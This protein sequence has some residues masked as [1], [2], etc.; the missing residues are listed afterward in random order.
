M[1]FKQYIK[2]LIRFIINGIPDVNLTTTITTLSKN[3]LLKGRTALITGGTSGIGKSIARSFLNAGATVI[4]TGRSKNKIDITIEDIKQSTGL[5]SVYGL[6]L[7]LANIKDMEKKFNE[8]FS[9]FGIESVDI[10]VNNAGVGHTETMSLIDD[11]DN[12]I[13]TNLKGTF[14]LSRIVSDYMIKNDIKGNILNISSTSSN[15]PASDSYMLSKWGVRGLT[16]GLAEKLI[17]YGIVVNAIAPGPTATPMLNK[18][19]NEN[20]YLYENP[21]KRYAQPEEI[22]NI[23]V[24]LV[25]NMSRLIVGDTIFMGGGAAI[26]SSES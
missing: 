23:A 24:I 15:R 4:I 21:S 1:D 9:I 25:S 3:D 13:N 8:I 18:N 22:A 11:F 14:F 7:D 6:I 19:G 2:R 20:L 16:L 17:K 5:D 12:I 26:I 10:L